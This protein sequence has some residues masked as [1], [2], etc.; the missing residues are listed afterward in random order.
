[1]IKVSD[2]I[3]LNE[4]DIVMIEKVDFDSIA[5]FTNKNVASDFQRLSENDLTVEGYR[6]IVVSFKDYNTR[7]KWLKDIEMQLIKLGK[8]IEF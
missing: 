1:M 5:F 6:K 4:N 3:I 2:D 8:M 7:E